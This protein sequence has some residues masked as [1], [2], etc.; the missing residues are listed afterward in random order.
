MARHVAATSEAADRGVVA[1]ADD[2]GLVKHAL[3]E[4]QVLAESIGMIGPSLGA[5]SLIPLAF[6]VAGGATWLTVLISTVGMLAMAAIIAFL[7]SRH[8]SIGA[9]YTLIPKGLGPTGGLLAAG[10]FGLIA[11]AGQ[12]ISVLGFGAALA[13]FLTTAFS[14][15]HSDRAELV[16]LDLAGLA[17]AVGVTMRGISLSTSILLL[18]EGVS[19]T[20]ISILLVVVLAKHGHIFN[21]SKLELHGASAHG[22]LVGM[23]YLVLAFGG[24]ESAAALGVEAKNPRR[25]VPIALLG[26]IVVVGLFFIINAYVQIL[27]FEGSGLQIAS[28]AVPLGTL[29]GH[30]GVKWLGD[31]VLLGV[32]MSWFG[33]LCAWSNYAPRPTLAMA[34][35]GVLPRW[36]G[37]TNA[38]TGVPIAAL[39][40]WATTWLV[41][42]LYFVVADVNLSQAFANVGALAGY[43]YTLLYLVAAVAAIGYAIRNGVR[44]AWFPL[45]AVVAGA[46]MVLEFWYSFNPLPAHPLDLYVYGFAIFVGVLLIGCVAGWVAA[47]NWMRRMGR[48]E[49]ANA[50]SN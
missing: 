48:I 20:A 39:L 29:A 40:F 2:T 43:G 49:E 34:D 44:R 24:F 5:A 36:L 23:T 16:V 11:L 10:G 46:V 33:V 30:Y 18:L 37:R 1:D 17:I 6:G 27:G 9:L 3:S 7:A 35:E 32:T 12:L 21:S 45:A 14:V 38:R 31:I 8:V 28:Q 19:M 15:G 25:A 22:V 41:F 42:S 50:G 4:I 26:S 47:P 13:Q